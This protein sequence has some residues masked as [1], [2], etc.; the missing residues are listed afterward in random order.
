MMEVGF[1]GLGRMG[2]GMALNLLRSDVSLTVFDTSAEAVRPLRAA[3]ARVAA[4][5]G[6]V[7]KNSEVVFTSLP[8][9]VQVDQVVLGPGGVL[10]S[11]GAGLVLFELSTS[12]LSLA[13][14]IHEAFAARGGAMLDAPISGGRQARPQVISPC[15]S[16]ATGECTTA[17]CRCCRRLVGHPVMSAGS[18]RARLPSSLTTWWAT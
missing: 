16:A 5:V 2:R 15:G 6:E 7:A 13:R 1:I 12:S 8:G 17:I 4:D 9:P 3:G 10:D 14:R 18:G 11:M